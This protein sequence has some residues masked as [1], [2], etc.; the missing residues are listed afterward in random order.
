[1]RASGREKRK[2]DGAERGYAIAGADDGRRGREGERG[3]GG[4]RRSEGGS[5]PL[6]VP[7]AGEGDRSHMGGSRMGKNC[8]FGLFGRVDPGP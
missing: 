4:G 7:P 6:L 5:S 8:S 2:K 1:M 3:R